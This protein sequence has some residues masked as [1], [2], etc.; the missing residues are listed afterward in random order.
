MARCVTVRLVDDLDGSTTDDV[1]TVV[2]GLDGAGYEIDLTEANASRLRTV[3]A[4]FIS[5]A[6]WV[7]TPVVDWHSRT[8]RDWARENGFPVYD[9]GRI[10]NDVIAAFHRAFER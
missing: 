4:E 3:L 8:I 9:R 1:H 5:A 7:D 10:R 6:R 2:F